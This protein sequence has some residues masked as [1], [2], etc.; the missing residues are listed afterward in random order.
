MTIPERLAWAKKANELAVAAV[1]RLSKAP[2]APWISNAP[3][4]YAIPQ[5]KYRNKA[6]YVD[7]L[8]FDSKLEADRY[9]ELK[10]LQASGE[11]AWFL[12]QVPF[13][14]A[15]GITYRLDYMVAWNYGK[16]WS[17]SSMPD[18]DVKR[19]GF[20]ECKGFMTALGRAKIAVIS[21]KYGI[22]IRILKRANVRKS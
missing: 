16:Y 19:I 21:E 22:Q 9:L 11:V 15:R 4:S 1:D 6:Q 18:V 10:A 14:V 20:E 5:S 17:A 7:G 13:Q 12:R 8:R 3:K 2:K